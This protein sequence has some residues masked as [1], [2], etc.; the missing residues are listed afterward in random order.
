M[1]R[2][3]GI[4][5]TLALISLVTG[6]AG[7]GWYLTFVH[8]PHPRH[9]SSR[10]LLRWMVQRDLRAEP[11]AV[12]LALADRLE[13]ELRKD[14]RVR[15]Q[16]ARLSTAQRKQL[17]ENFQQLKS[18]WFV[19]RSRQ[20][21]QQPSGQRFAFLQQQMQTIRLLAELHVGDET[22]ESSEK[23][24]TSFFDDVHSWSN[25]ADEADHQ[26][27]QRA[28]HDG[29]VC[30]LAT[31]DVH[32]QTGDTRRE[33]ADRIAAAL[34]NGAQADV[35]Y[36]F[37]LSQRQRATLRDNAV[38]LFEAWFQDQAEAYER[39]PAELRDAFVTRQIQRVN[40]WGILELLMQADGASQKPGSLLK[41]I[42]LSKLANRWIE[43]AGDE[44]GPRMRALFAHVQRQLLS[45]DARLA[46]P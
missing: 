24:K 17:R 23:R 29:V 19:S 1:R 45:G 21:V 7:T 46:T 2:H 6:G 40:Q 8:L 44:D 10:Q 42:G 36:R 26:C 39:A 16:A 33:L 38:L 27:V 9:A 18:V 12:R 32:A 25:Q 11:H 20:Y 15:D 34:D 28:V 5:T 41:L 35:G 22:S 4:L 3:R 13:Q 43:R 30:W 31:G 37:S 14:L